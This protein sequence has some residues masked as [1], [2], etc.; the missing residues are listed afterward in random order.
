MKTKSLILGL[1]AFVFAIGSAFTSASVAQRAWIKAKPSL[2]GDPITCID[3]GVDCN[4]T[5]ANPVC[6]IKVFQT[7]TNTLVTVNA[8][9]SE[10]DCEVQLHD[11]RAF[12]QSP[13][14]VYEAFN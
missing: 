1:L 6:K 2:A 11:T 5:A 4:G 9:Q 12:V 8:Y 14:N 7:K 13:I 10:T 3:S